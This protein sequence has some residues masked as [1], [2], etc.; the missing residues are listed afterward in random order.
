MM[1]IIRVIRMQFALF[2]SLF[3]KLMKAANKIL[4]LKTKKF[5]EFIDLTSEVENFIKKSNI[6]NGFVSVYSKHTTLAVRINEKE[7]GF[8]EDCEKMMK[9]LFPH[10]TYYR[11]ND[12]NIRTENVVCSPGAT[13]CANGHSHIIHLLMGTSETVPVVNRKPILGT[14]QRIFAIELDNARHRE[15]FVQIIGE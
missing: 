3:R 11:H 9:K 4:K 1:R 14:Y 10:N 12:L 13:D 5:M 7:K 15:L 8:F 6:K 2:V